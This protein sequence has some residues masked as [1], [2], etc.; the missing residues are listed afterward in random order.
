M[1]GDKNVKEIHY[2]FPGKN[3]VNFEEGTSTEGVCIGCELKPCLEYTKEQI[4]IQ[5]IDGMPYNND[6]KVC[7]SMQLKK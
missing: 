1:K 5:V 2:K 4:D 3:L 6:R 7:P